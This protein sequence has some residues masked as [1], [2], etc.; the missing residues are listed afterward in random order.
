[1]K[2]AVITKEKTYEVSPLPELR[3]RRQYTIVVALI[4]LLAGLNYVLWV[5][6]RVSEVIQVEVPVSHMSVVPASATPDQQIPPN[7]PAISHTTTAV[8]KEPAKE[9]PLQG[10]KKKAKRGANK[11]QIEKADISITGAVGVG[12]LAA[13]SQYL[14]KYAPLAV[15]EM[16]KHGIPA[17]IT[18]A[19]AIVESNV[20]KSALAFS[21]NNHF[22]IKCQS[23]NCR[24]G[25][26][27]NRTDDHHKDFFRKYPSVADSYK[28]HSVFLKQPRYRNC[29]AHNKNYKEWAK[30]LQRSGYATD[31]TYAAKLVA[32]IEKHNLGRFDK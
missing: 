24:R 2:F 28:H 6:T 9:H 20:G 11:R 18:L 32:T 29:F 26:C 23:R 16:R 12:D 10:R 13:V 17:S 31:K 30:E 25:H 14:K 19:Q 1:M 4:I 21:N 27:T 5:P 22:G 8:S 15:A 7:N 3:S